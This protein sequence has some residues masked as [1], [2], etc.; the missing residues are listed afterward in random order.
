MKFDIVEVLTRSWKITWKYKVLWIFGILASCGRRSGGNFNSSGSRN[1]GGISDN[2]LSPEMMRQAEAFFRSV[3]NWLQHNE[4]IIF[5]LIAF[6]FI[7]IILQI[8]FTLVGTAGLVRGVVKAENG[9]EHLVFGQL[10]SESLGYFW[11]LLGSALVIWIPYM[12]IFI[13]SLIAILVPAIRGRVNETAMASGLILFL[14]AFCCCM[15]PISIALSLYHVQ[16][17]RSIIVE[18]KGV[19]SALGRGWQVLS[20]NI[21]GLIIIA[22]V[23]FIAGLIFGVILALPVLLVVVPLMTL[24]LQGNITSWRPF[25]GAG[26]FILCY[27]PVAWFI[28]GILTTYT[29]SVWTLVYLRVTTPKQEAPVI[30]EANA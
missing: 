21:I 23:L 4:W 8:F 22:I 11:R 7:S 2:P 16:V 12:T 15:L 28:T 14:L 18:D 3:G 6:V 20:Q 24:F 25:I 27:S 13:L 19:F 29:E 17:K 5:A 30:V 1:S 26:A 10:F 9:V